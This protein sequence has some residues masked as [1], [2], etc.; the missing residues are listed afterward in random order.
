MPAI[1]AIVSIG[2][3]VARRVRVQRGERA[4]VAGV[5][6]LEHVERFAAAALADDDAVRPHAQRVA[7][8]VADRDSPVAF[9]V[10]GRDS[11]AHDV[12][13]LSLQLGGVFDRDDALV[14][15]G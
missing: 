10:G 3:R 7:D 8:E 15:P 6:R 9:D 2:D 5:H 4:V 14:V 12:I 13:L 11:S 1:S